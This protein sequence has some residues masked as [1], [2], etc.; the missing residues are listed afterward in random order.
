[1]RALRVREKLDSIRA[2]GLRFLR[3]SPASVLVLGFEALLV[4]CAILLA[5]GSGALA[6]GVAVAAYFVLVA[7]VALQLVWFSWRKGKDD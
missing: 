2:R 1:V 5:S 3:S 7:G 4:V 6:E